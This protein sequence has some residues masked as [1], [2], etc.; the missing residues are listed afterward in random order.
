MWQIWLAIAPEGIVQI[1]QPIP[2]GYTHV[3]EESL[4]SLCRHL[5]IRFAWAVRGSKEWR[6]RLRWMGLR[7]DEGVVIASRSVE[8]LRRAITLRGDDLS[9]LPY[10]DSIPGWRNLRSEVRRTARALWAAAEFDSLA[11][12]GYRD[13]LAEHR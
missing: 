8:K 2:R 7:T 12:A 9:V 6:R 11:R 4:P 3:Q 10:P 13:W 5:R 1:E